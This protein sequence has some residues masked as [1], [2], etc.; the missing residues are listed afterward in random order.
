MPQ[1]FL[2]LAALEVQLVP[3]HS[4]NWLEH[5]SGS[6]LLAL[7]AIAAASLA[8]LVAT[9]NHRGQLAHD[10]EMRNRDHTRDTIDAAVEGANQAIDRAT[11]FSAVVKTGARRGYAPRSGRKGEKTKQ[12]KDW[13][14][15]VVDSMT[16][17]H[18]TNVAMQA[19][20]VRLELRL[21]LA[22]EIVNKQS[23]LRQALSD[24]EDVLR[25]YLTRN[26]D[27]AEVEPFNDDKSA[28]NVGAVFGEFR[29]ACRDWFED[30]PVTRSGGFKKLAS[31]FNGH[32]NRPT[33]RDR[34]DS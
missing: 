27:A 6:I 24:W 4:E 28:E 34:L 2:H 21:G 15:E 33:S 29:G 23:S 8:A 10:R 32:G 7:A 14:R 22:H 20:N 25:S 19:N 1:S 17:A 3:T 16:A 11:D 9:L 5:N 30:Q 18:Q 13:E 31:W 26:E 12:Q